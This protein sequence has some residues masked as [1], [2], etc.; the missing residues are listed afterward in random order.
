MAVSNSIEIHEA[1][2]LLDAIYLE[3]VEQAQFVFCYHAWLTQF[4]WSDGT[5]DAV[6][7]SLGQVSGA[8][9]QDGEDLNSGADLFYNVEENGHQKGISRPSVLPFIFF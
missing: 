8:A 4:L 9:D 7:H 1:S 6:S 3:A 2:G 5:P